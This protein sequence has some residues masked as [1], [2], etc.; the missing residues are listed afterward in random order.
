MRRIDNLFQLISGPTYKESYAQAKAANICLRCGRPANGFTD[1]SSELEYRIS[2]LCQSCQEECFSRPA[3][4]RFIPR[5][6]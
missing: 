5:T 4:D 1:G 2:A 6:S 3:F